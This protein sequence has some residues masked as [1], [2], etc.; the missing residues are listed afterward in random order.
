MIIYR[1]EKNGFGFYYTDHYEIFNYTFNTAEKHP[2]PEIDWGNTNPKNYYY[3]FQSLEQLYDWF[4]KKHKLLNDNG[5][6][7]LLYRIHKKYVKF[8]KCEKQLV[9]LKEKSKLLGYTKFNRQ[10]KLEFSKTA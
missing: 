5:Y 9:F 6:R 10:K 2:L 8:S 3:G 7:I 1:V 4:H